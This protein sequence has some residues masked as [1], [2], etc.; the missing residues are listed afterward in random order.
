M[1]AKKLDPSA[2]VAALLGTKVRRL[3][4]AAG[5]TQQELG[6]RVFVS[7]TRIAKVELATDPPG[8]RLTEQLDEALNA[9]SALN[10]LWPH[11]SHS[12]YPDFSQRFMALQASASTIHEF[13]QVVPGLLQTEA[14]ARAMLRAGQVYGD[15]DLEE[16][17]AAR[18]DRQA[19]LDRDDAPWLWTILDEAALYRTVGKRTTMREQLAHLVKMAERDR[20]CLR[21]CPRGRVDPAAMSGSMTTL[22]GRDGS[23]SV[24]LEG[25]RSGALSEDAEDVLRHTVVFDRLTA[26]ALDPGKSAELISKV[27]EETY[28]CAST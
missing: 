8:R 14:Y 21:I 17:V 22:T 18:V 3:R 26:N 11:L 2:S 9:G 25:I 1:P 10:E 6:D 24:Y 5:L 16:S 15:W 20:I 23:R 28:S 7:H 13:C 19:I 4:E 12:P 27:M